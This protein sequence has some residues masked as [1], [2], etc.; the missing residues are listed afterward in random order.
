MKVVITIVLAV[1]IIVTLLLAMVAWDYFHQLT[2][3]AGHSGFS[4]DVV[5]ALESVNQVVPSGTE[6]VKTSYFGQSDLTDILIV[7]HRWFFER[8]ESDQPWQLVG[9]ITP[10]AKAPASPKEVR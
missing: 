3:I 5:Q 4:P 10:V 8:T 1:W 9:E 6:I 2:T 7:D